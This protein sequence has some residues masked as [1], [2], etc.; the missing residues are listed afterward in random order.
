MH[1][2][3]HNQIKTQAANSQHPA[4]NSKIK[5]IHLTI[6]QHRINT[7][8]WI[9]IWIWTWTYKL[10]PHFSLLN[11]NPTTW[12]NLRTN[13]NYSLNSIIRP[14]PNLLIAK[15]PIMLNQQMKIANRVYRIKLYNTKS[16]CSSNRLLNWW[17]S[18]KT[19]EQMI[20]ECLVYRDCRRWQVA[21]SKA[22][23]MSL[24]MA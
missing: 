17:D 23:K 15:I 4:R 16:H 6:Q 2:N 9:S 5:H 10:F 7:L 24:I 11:N 14:K 13:N 1:Y 19:L 8:G 21:W 22:S 3:C 12:S 20:I 18:T